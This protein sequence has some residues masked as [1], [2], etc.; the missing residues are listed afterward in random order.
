MWEFP[1]R[2][3]TGIS[4]LIYH[5][6]FAA[7][8]K[9][10]KFWKFPP[11]N[12]SYIP[13]YL[14]NCSESRPRTNIGADDR[15]FSYHYQTSIQWTDSLWNGCIGL[16]HGSHNQH[17]HPRPH[18]HHPAYLSSSILSSTTLHTAHAFFYAYLSIP[19]SSTLIVF[20]CG[21]LVPLLARQSSNL[22]CLPPHGISFCH[23]FTTLH[24][25]GIKIS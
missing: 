24:K 13:Y 11:P 14:S 6:M 1:I 18:H 7:F 19:F 25:R 3:S 20:P 21:R 17:Q 8:W 9:F 16:C 12:I 22:P 23:F 15:I 5:N 4:Y 2:K 10:W